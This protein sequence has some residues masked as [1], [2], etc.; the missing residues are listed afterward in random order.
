MIITLFYNY[1]CLRYTLSEIITLSLLLLQNIV[2]IIHIYFESSVCNNMLYVGY[3]LY[4]RGPQPLGHTA[5]G[6]QQARERS[7]ICRSLSLPI[8][9]IIAWTIPPITLITAWTIPHLPPQFFRGKIVFHEASPW[10]Q[11]GWGPLLYSICR[12]YTYMV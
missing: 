11:K 1:I 8:A 2:T 6:D 9:R 3:M 4:S 10:C 5:G 7:F 12:V